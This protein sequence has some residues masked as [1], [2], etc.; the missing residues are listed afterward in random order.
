MSSNLSDLYFKLANEKDSELEACE[1]LDFYARKC[2]FDTETIDEM[3][4][5]FIE[6]IINAK[7]HA[8][9]EP[10]NPNKEKIDITLSYN[11]DNLSIKVR[12][13]G[14]G[15]D[16]NQVEKPDIKKKL[17]SSYKRGW[18]LMLME[19]L[20]DGAEITSFPPSGTLI[21]LVKKRIV[22]ETKND[23]ELELERK[24]F[25]R[26]K[27]VLGSFIDLS[28]FLCQ[29]KNLQS[30][31]RSMLRILLGTLGVTRGAIYTFSP[32]RDCLSCFVDIKLKANARLPI[33]QIS[34]EFF[35]KLAQKADGN[36]TEIVKSELK[37]FSDTFKDNEVEHICVLKTDEQNHGLLVLGGRFHKEQ[38]DFDN[39]LLTIIARNIS[40]AINTYKLMQNLKD[41]NS[42][43]DKRLLELDSVREATQVISSELELENMPSTVEGLFRSLLGIRKFSMAIYDPLEKRFNICNNDRGLPS[44]ID[45]W[46]SPVSQ[47]VI[48]NKEPVLVKN[49]NSDPRFTYPRAKNYASDSFAVIPV[50]MQNELLA[51][52]NLSDK[53]GD[54]VINDR[55]YELSRLICSQ[56]GIAIKNA[57]LYKQG[58]TDSLTG[59]YTNHY[60]RMRLE[61]EISR[62]KRIKSPLSLI[63]VGID[64]FKELIESSGMPSLKDIIIKKHGSSIKRVIR[65]NDL[66][67]RLEG[68]K[69]VILMP[70][71]TF[72]GASIAAEKIYNNIKDFSFKANNETLKTTVTLSVMQYDLKINAPDLIEL[73]EKSLINGQNE[74]GNKIVYYKG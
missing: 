39:E 11:N 50:V 3:R 68:D 14:K 13:Y 33:I 69:F 36:V 35:D 25:E 60:F 61:Q 32:E 1:L 70:D 38:E 56:L 12:D 44:S 27:Y 57:N 26:L 63:M 21:H 23:G 8:P 18:G 48:D 9:K 4:L 73:A 45:L 24:R 64:K 49:I 37:A 2:G 65:F 16:P 5:A 62:L 43:L 34:K 10:E 59:M 53:E 42:V 7:E 28:S 29:S 20:M 51:I 72:E 41:A 15:F 74:G 46:S 54:G 31:L 19:R 67:C 71:T 6:A 55:D 40:S 30:G 58:I 17:K 52:V 66:A 22:E 47:Y